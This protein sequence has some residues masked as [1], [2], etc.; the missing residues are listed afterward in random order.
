[1]P[2]L[3]EVETVRAGLAPSLEGAKITTVKTG[4]DGLRYPFPDKLSVRLM[5]RHIMALTRRAKYL[6][7]ELDDDTV[8]ISH[9]GMSGSWRIR[10]ENDA[11]CPPGKYDRHDHFIMQLE[12]DGVRFDAVYNDPRRFGFL[13]LSARGELETMPMLL[14]LGVEPTGNALS[15]IYL[16]EKFSRKKTPLKTALLDQAI[17]AGLGN[18]Y[19]C[20]ALWRAGLSPVMKAEALGADQPH[21]LEAAER[22]AT[23]IRDVIAKAICAGGSTLRDYRHADGSL[24]Y[25]QHNFKVYGREGEACTKCGALIGRIVQ[26]GRSSFYCEGCQSETL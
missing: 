9:L 10:H 15:G 5:S 4:R 25:F 23:A 26:A 21:G 3:P 14:K 2:E 7:I 17:I 16:A 8:L 13:L 12:K 11:H 1:M 22:L 18:I 20:E 6:L 19:V 24:G